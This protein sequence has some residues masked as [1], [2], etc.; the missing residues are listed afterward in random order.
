MR[1]LSSMASYYVTEPLGATSARG[2]SYQYSYESHY[3]QPPVDDELLDHGGGA[4]GDVFNAADYAQYHQHDPTLSPTGID[5]QL[6]RHST[7]TQRVRWK[8]FIKAL[9]MAH[10][11]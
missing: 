10:S 8:N 9:S 1:S 11:Y 6:E 5:A 7:Q 3:D 4:T 2:S